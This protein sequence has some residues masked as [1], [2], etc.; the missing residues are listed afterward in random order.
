MRGYDAWAKDI[1]S[2]LRFKQILSAFRSESV[3]IDSS[4]K[5]YQIRWFIRRFNFMAKKIFYLGPD[6]SFDEGGVTMRS[7]F[8]PI[9]QYSKAKPENYRVD[10]LILADARD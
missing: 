1:M 2:L 7:R 9:K 10:F 3:Q 4:D 5:Y 6:A 8:C